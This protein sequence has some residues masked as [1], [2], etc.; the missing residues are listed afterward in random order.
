MGRDVEDVGIW[1][2]ADSGCPWGLKTEHSPTLILCDSSKCFDRFDVLPPFPEIHLLQWLHTPPFKLAVMCN[3]TFDFR[4]DIE[5]IV[6][7]KNDS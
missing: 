5:L 6:V 4:A 2:A 7:S 1:E 3:H